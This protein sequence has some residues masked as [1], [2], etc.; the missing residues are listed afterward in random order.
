MSG[1]A[2]SER[3][4]TSAAAP[5]PAGRRPQIRG[6]WAP[7]AI[8]LLA[9]AVRLVAIAATPHYRPIDDSADFDRYAVSLATHGT[10]PDSQLAPGPTAFRAPGF[11]VLLAGVYR[12]VGT[13]SAG[14][15][16]EAGRVLEALLGVLT[17]ALVYLIARRLWDRRVALLAGALAAI[18]PPLVLIGTSLMSEGLYIPL[19]LAAV[20]AALVC[21]EHPGSWG[22]PALT[23]V[24]VGLAALTRSTDLALAIPVAF[25]VWSA[26]PRRAWRSLR[27]PLLVLGLCAITITPWI[28]RDWQVMHTFVPITDEGGYALIGTYNREAAARTDYPALYTPPV[29]ELPR[30]GPQIRGLNEARA[31]NRLSDDAYSYI[32]AHPAYVAKVALYSTLRLFDLTGTG[33]E[34]Y[35]EPTWGYDA[36]FAVVGV[37]AF[38]IVGALALAGLATA[39]ARR[40]GWAFW[41]CPVALLAPSVPVIGAAR[42]RSPADPFVVMLAALALAAA[43][44]RLRPNRARGGVSPEGGLS[45]DPGLTPEGG[46]PPGGAPVGGRR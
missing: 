3:A 1:F 40:A 8:L 19:G 12:L 7:A 26:R 44:G 9:L 37:Y 46:L 28:V 23:G 45:P 18:F 39:G 42:Y 35:I 16:W 6:R 25:L 38:W 36:T 43:W 14:T 11:P 5:V 24:L 15:R 29:V 33:F 13:A 34:R 32:E 21:R 27:P 30:L 41:M 22:W 4:G 17:V 2:V 31:A 20:L 10:F